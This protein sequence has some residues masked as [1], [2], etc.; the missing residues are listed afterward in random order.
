MAKNFKDKNINRV[1]N[2]NESPTE[3]EFVTSRGLKV[4][5]R[6]LPPY[7]VQMASTAIEKPEPPSYIVKTEGGGEEIHTHDQESIMQSSPEEQLEWSKYLEKVREADQKATDVL[8]NVVL[9]EGVE[10]TIPDK[11]RWIKRQKLMGLTVPEDEDEMMLMFKKTQVIGNDKDVEFIVQSV[12][13]IGGIT[14]EDLNSV[15]NSFQ[16]KLESES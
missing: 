1:V 6:P 13:K 3:I 11:E 7:L 12:M 16:D 10:V 8:I 5:L 4:T 15:K 9:V 14:E 2:I